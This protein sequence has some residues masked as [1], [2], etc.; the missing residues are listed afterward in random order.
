VFGPVRT[1]AFAGHHRIAMAARL[2][3]IHRARIGYAAAGSGSL[4]GE[5]LAGLGI[6]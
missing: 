5:T 3:V 4:R 6:E 1:A 2:D